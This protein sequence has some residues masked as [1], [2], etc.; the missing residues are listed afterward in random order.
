GYIAI[1]VPVLA[2][3]IAVVQIA[4]AGAVPPPWNRAPLVALLIQVAC[5]LVPQFLVI[6][7]GPAN[8]QLLA[9]LFLGLGMLSFLTATFGLGIIGTMLASRARSETVEVFRSAAT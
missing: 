5:W 4:R 2:G 6:A 1:I 8:A 9:S 3:L 7:L